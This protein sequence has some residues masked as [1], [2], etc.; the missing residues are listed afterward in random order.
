VYEKLKKNQQ[1]LQDANKA[2]EILQANRGSRSQLAKAH[3]RRGYVVL[4]LP[5]ET[6]QAEVN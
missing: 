2:L 4:S 3:L 5:A 6:D 1:A